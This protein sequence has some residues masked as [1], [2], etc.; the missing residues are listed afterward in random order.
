[1]H[2]QFNFNVKDLRSDGKRT[3]KHERVSVKIH[4]AQKGEDRNVVPSPASTLTSKGIL[5][6][7]GNFRSTPAPTPSMSK[8]AVNFK[9]EAIAILREMNSNQNKA[10]ANFEKLSQRVDK[11]YNMQGEY[12]CEAEAFPVYDT[13]SQS[14]THLDNEE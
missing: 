10:N 7:T 5:Q 6:K 9:S 11:L 8:A 4:C 2:A 3:I 1:M 12:E 14:F 13:Q